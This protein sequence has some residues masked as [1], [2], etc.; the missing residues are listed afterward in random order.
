MS[1]RDRV[2]R[3]LDSIHAQTLKY[4]LRVWRVLNKAA[5]KVLAATMEH[6]A[7][8]TWSDE[9]WE[10]DAADLFDPSRPPTRTLANGYYWGWL[11]EADPPHW[12]PFQR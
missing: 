10:H 5:N 7:P 9:R 4:G 2:F 12:E 11:S 1:A 3:V 8:V 6:D